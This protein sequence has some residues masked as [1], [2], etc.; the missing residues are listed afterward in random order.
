MLLKNARVMSDA[1]TLERL[2]IRIAGEKI[3]ELEI[4]EADCRRANE[5]VFELEDKLR[6][7]KQKKEENIKYPTTSTGAQGS[8]TGSNV[9]GSAIPNSILR[10]ANTR[11]VPT[12]AATA[13]I[14]VVPERTEETW[15][16]R[17]VKSSKPNARNTLSRGEARSF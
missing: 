14:S 10:S 13:K 4:K 7:A 15:S 5:A 6:Q 2:D 8:I 3:A 16:A 11:N 17:T 1:F 9:F 12:P